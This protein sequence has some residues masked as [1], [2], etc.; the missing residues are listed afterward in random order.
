VAKSKAGFFG[1]HMLVC[2]EDGVFGDEVAFSNFSMD[3]AGFKPSATMSYRSPTRE[4][5]H[6]TVAGSAGVVP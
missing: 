4:E 2:D 3:A 5:R 1:E 6:G